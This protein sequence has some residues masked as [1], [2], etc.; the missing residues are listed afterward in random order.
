MIHTKKA[1]TLIELLIV[2]AIIG[3]LAAIAVPNFLNA[4]MRAKIAK[5]QADV[6][7]I[8]TAIQTY[9][10][11]RND[12]PADMNTGGWPSYMVSDIPVLTT[13]IAYMTSIPR[14]PFNK[15]SN[16]ADASWVP[17]PEEFLSSEYFTN[18]GSAGTFWSP[19]SGPSE[20]NGTQDHRNRLA[21][22]Y[23][24]GPSM[25]RYFPGEGFNRGCWHLDFE[26]SNGLKSFGSIR[27]FVP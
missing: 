18:K 24:V 5:V 19:F 25:T 17:N 21:I 9:Q 26:A 7:A 2:V 16:T 22:L 27:R 6:Q 12:V 8:A 11:D 20:Y 10:V 14:D 13:P 1:F 15:R 23:S 3:I 4:Q